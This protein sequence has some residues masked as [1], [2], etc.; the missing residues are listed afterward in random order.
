MNIITAK[1]KEVFFAVLPVTIIVLILNFTIVPLENIVIIRFVIG[2]VFVVIGLM[3]F[4]LGVDNGITPIGNLIGEKIAKS[5]RLWIVILSGLVLGFFISIAEPDLHIL[6]DQVEIVTSGLI[7]KVHIV[8]VVSIGIAVMVSIGFIRIV[9][10]LALYKI[11]MAAYGFIFILSLFSSKEFLA[12]AFDSSG[13]TTGALAVPFILA[14][15]IGISALK[16]DSKASEKDSFGLIAVASTGAI[17]T[18]LIMGIISGTRNLTGSIPNDESM[19]G[20][21]LGPFLHEIPIV[22]VEIFYALA[23][24]VIIFILGNIAEFK[25]PKKTFRRI[26]VGLI[27]T[28]LGLIIFLAGV[29]AGFM[30]A[31]RFVGYKVA[32]YD[33][34]GILLLVGFL[35]GVLTILAEPAVHVLTHQVEG[36]TSG[37]INR[38]LILAALS[39]GVGLA[40]ALSML[41]IIIPEMQLW[42]FLLPGYFIAVLLTFFAPK[43]FVGI[44][45]DS[46]GVAS[47]PMTATFILAFA[48]GA[49]EAIEGANVL[50]DGFGIIAMVAMTPIITLQILGLMFRRKSELKGD[51][52]NV[53]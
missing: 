27:F 14:L 29:N 53:E 21:V 1:L 34:K 52:L 20:S 47:G 35:L 6:A 38:K 37:Y 46:G 18:V 44:A 7:D 31:G 15:S 13:A 2:A 10:N 45:F 40:I 3:I 36:V 16:K 49:A 17:I 22:A 9:Y 28:F 26:A 8:V 11:L 51:E 43:L 23:P 42:H 30:E 25:L 48:R 19:Y 12:I 24:I 5:N 41:R 4:L 32:L 50:I 39:L 33:N